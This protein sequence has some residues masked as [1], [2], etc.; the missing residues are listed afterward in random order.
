MESNKMAEETTETQTPDAPELS[1][2]DLSSVIKII[3]VVTKRGAFDGGEMADVGAVRNRLAAFLEHATGQKHPEEATPPESQ[4]D[5][6]EKAEE[7]KA[8]VKDKDT[9][10]S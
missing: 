9:K 8:R 10:K 7:R 6:D 4:T 2:I 1:L 3:D 5:T